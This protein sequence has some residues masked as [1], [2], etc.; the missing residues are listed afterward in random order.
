MLQLTTETP[1][2]LVPGREIV[3]VDGDAGV[4]ES[5]DRE[6]DILALEIVEETT[7]DET[8]CLGRSS[9]DP[10]EPELDSAENPVPTTSINLVE[11]NPRVLIPEVPE[12]ELADEGEPGVTK[13]QLI[14]NRLQDLI[15][16]LHSTTL[17]RDEANELE[18]MFMDAKRQLYEAVL[19]GRQMADG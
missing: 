16:D 10:T 17:S 11:A 3:V 14:R 19:R 12:D 13:V 2:I 1:E 6:E 9:S 4:T 15:E 18:D 8:I 5:S 7:F